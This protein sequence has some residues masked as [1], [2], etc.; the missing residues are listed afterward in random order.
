MSFK[1]LA[2]G[3]VFP[4]N[5]ANKYAA[6]TFISALNKLYP[7]KQTNKQTKLVTINRNI[8]MFTDLER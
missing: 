5:T 7:R 8:N 2:E 3:Q 1:S 6:I 4:P